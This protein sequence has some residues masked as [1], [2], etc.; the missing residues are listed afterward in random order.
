MKIKD[1]LQSNQW[2]SITRMLHSWW[3]STNDK[4]LYR[5][6]NECWEIWTIALFLGRRS[7]SKEKF[8][9]NG[10]T[11][12]T[13]PQDAV[14]ADVYTTGN[15]A[16]LTSWAN[17]YAKPEDIS[18]DPYDWEQ[19]YGWVIDEVQMSQQGIDDYKHAIRSNEGK[20][21]CDGSY[22]AGY[23]TAAFQTIGDNVIKG[24]Q[25][26]VPGYKKDQSSYRAELGG[27]LKCPSYYL[28][29][30]ARKNKSIRVLWSWGAIVKEQ[31]R[32]CPVRDLLLANGTHMIFL[33]ESKRKIRI[34]TLE[35]TFKHVYGH[36]DKKRKK[37]KIDNWATTNIAAD[38]EAK[39]KWVRYKQAGFPTIP[40]NA[41]AYGLWRII[42]KSIQSFMVLVKVL[43]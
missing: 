35:W 42:L 20:I 21:V 1:E 4:R 40:Y 19:Q 31:L 28:M 7:W 24:Q 3:Y 2:T 13:L 8:Q 33:R 15:T 12:D 11:L 34:S 29:L 36:Q 16:K 18:H 43:L 41:E 9:S 22:K 14:P 10:N 5:Q 23:S 17:I 39:R 37:K 6:R 27:I 26:I 30:C 38:K 32:L 25:N